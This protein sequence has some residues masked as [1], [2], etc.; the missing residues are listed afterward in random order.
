MD[1]EDRNLILVSNAEPYSHEWEDDEIACNRVAGGLTSALDPM[2]RNCDGTWVAWGRGDADF[3]VCDSG[4]KIRVPEDGDKQYDLKRI[5]LTEDEKEGFYYGFSNEVLWPISHSLPERTTL[6]DFK[7]TKEN[8]K[9]YRRVNKKYADA[10][11]EEISGDDELIW[12]HDYHLTLLA[13]MIKEEYPDADIALFWHIPWPSWETFGTLP[14]RNEIMDGLLAND[15]IGVHTDTIKEN[16]LYCARRL[17]ASVDEKGGKIHWNDDVTQVNSVP[18]GIDYQMFNSM[19][20]KESNR[21]EA[22]NLREKFRTD[23]IILSVDRLDYTKGIPQRLDAFEL[24][25]E[26]YPEFREEVTL[27]QRI[28]PS[29]SNVKEYQSTLERINKMVGEINGKYEK[30]GWSPVKS[31]HRY[32]PQQEMLIPYYLSADVA[33][34]TPLNDGM[35]LVSKEYVACSDDGV[36]I[37]S[38]FAGAKEKLDEAILVNPWNTEEVAEAIKKALTMPEAERKERL[39]SMKEKVKQKNLEWWRKRFI[40]DWLNSNSS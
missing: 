24:F 16:F 30:V 9:I 10:V 34:V 18:I 25:L 31:F 38:E 11:M 37:L 12:I 5:E 14:W 15:F 22:E 20:Q 32:L 17:G 26:E 27:V 35:N 13:K 8:W 23:K 33:L 6:S 36:L 2:M 3:E 39:K 40:N 19:A 28:P 7:Y 4:G 1:L 29:R 21:K